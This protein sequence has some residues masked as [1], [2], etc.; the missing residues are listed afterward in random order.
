MN[1]NQIKGD[2]N[3]LSR[4]LK[5]KWSTLTNE[6]LAEIAGRRGQLVTVLQD[7]YGYA[8]DRAE[9]E[10]TKFIDGMTSWEEF[11]VEQRIVLDD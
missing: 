2:W 4:R 1:W 5:E 10:L 7:P 9:M 8:K 3:Q 6:D 11:D